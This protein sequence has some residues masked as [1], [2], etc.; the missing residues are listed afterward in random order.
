VL[1]WYHDH[2]EEFDA[3][4]AVEAA[5]DEAAEAAHRATTGS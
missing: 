4:L 5:A 3:E 1:A 2:R